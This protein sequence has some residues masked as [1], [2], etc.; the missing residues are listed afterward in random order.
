MNLKYS[1]DHNMYPSE[2]C[3]VIPAH[4]SM[5]QWGWSIA[6]SCQNDVAN[7]SDDTIY[8]GRQNPNKYR[9]GKIQEKGMERE[10]RWALSKKLETRGWFYASECHYNH[11]IS[12]LWKCPG[13]CEM[14]HLDIN[15]FRS[16]L[17]LINWH[18]LRTAPD[19]WWQ[20]SWGDRQGPERDLGRV[21]AKESG[22]C[23]DAGQLWGLQED[24]VSQST[25]KVQAGRALLRFNMTQDR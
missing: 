5:I 11:P 20:N 2:W 18:S 16:W 25:L 10:T 22:E 14:Q 8:S 9:I 24:I 12:H 6:L 3:S 21:S 4:A 7:A 1:I 17:E 13:G 19:K 23:H 15:R